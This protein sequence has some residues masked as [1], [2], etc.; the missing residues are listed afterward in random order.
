MALVV[1]RVSCAIEHPG[2][3]TDTTSRCGEAKVLEGFNG[4]ASVFQ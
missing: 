3:W 2:F 4:Y 1:L